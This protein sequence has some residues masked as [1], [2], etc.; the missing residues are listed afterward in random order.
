MTDGKDKQDEFA[1]G[2][3]GDNKLRDTFRF[4]QKPVTIQ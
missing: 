4:A 2:P 1:W 3:A